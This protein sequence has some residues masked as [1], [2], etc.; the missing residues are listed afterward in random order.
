LRVRDPELRDLIPDEGREVNE[1]PYWT[2]R[3]RDGDV[4]LVSPKPAVGAGTDRSA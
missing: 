1:S 3:L 2:R 4:I